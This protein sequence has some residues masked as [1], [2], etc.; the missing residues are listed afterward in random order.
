MSESTTTVGVLLAGGR[1]RR[2]GGGDKCLLPL[3]VQTLL[4]RGIERAQPQVGTLLLSANGN[5]LRFARTRLTVVADLYPDNPG[6]LAG[7]HAALKWMTENQPNEEWLASF[8]CDS[9]F[10]PRDLVARLQ[11][12]AV[13]ADSRLALACSAGRVHPVFALWHASLLKPI[14]EQLQSGHSPS[15]QEWVNAQNPVE[16][17]FAF[18]DLDPFF[19]INSPQDLY[20]AEAML[21]GLKD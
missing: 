10:F 16:V 5:A 20:A 4:Q 17:D 12:A 18:E 3:G 15:L 9:P 19:N 8:A 11:E 13:A 14:E 1:A 6:P 7:I 21:P 2:M